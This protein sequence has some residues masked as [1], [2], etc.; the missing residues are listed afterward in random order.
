METFLKRY[1]KFFYYIL[2]IPYK[3]DWE[4]GLLVTIHITK[5]VHYLLWLIRLFIKFAYAIVCW[6][7]FLHFLPTYL[8]EK[9]YDCIAFHS[10]WGM[11]TLIVLLHQLPHLTESDEIIQLSG[12]I[13]KLIK[14]LEN[15]KFQHLKRTKKR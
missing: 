15:G 2:S 4:S 1:F 11:I 7:L 5:S 3:L 14:K 12:S 6:T 10:E 13:V 8:K 9:R